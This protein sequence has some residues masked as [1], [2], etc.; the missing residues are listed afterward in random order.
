MC[1]ISG[2]FALDFET[3]CRHAEQILGAMAATLE[4]RGPDEVGYQ[5][6]PEVCFGFTR[7]AII[8]LETGQ[9]PHY[10][11][12]RSVVCI[13]NG[14]IYN[15]REL[16]EDLEKKGHRLRTRSDVEVL[17][18]LYEEHG[19][20]LVDR[21]NGQF[22]FALYDRSRRR[23]LGARDHVG[24]CP[25]YYCIIGGHLVFASEIKAI[26][27]YPGFQPVIDR[28]GLDQILTFPGLA[29]PRT[30]FEGV[31]ALP[32]GHLLIADGGA[33]RV[34]EYWDLEY[35][36]TGRLETPRNS[37]EVTEQLRALLTRAVERRLQADVPVGFYLSGGLDSTLVARLIHQLRPSDNWD[38]FS[39]GFDQAAIDEQR[40]QNIALQGIKAQRHLTLF[41]WKQISTRLPQAIWHAETPLKESYNTCSL[42]LSSMVR[43][44]GYKVILTGEGAD[45][46]FGGYVGYRLDRLRQPEEFPEPEHILEQDLREQLWGDRYFVY[47]RDYYALRSMKEAIYSEELVAGLDA[48][49]STCS[50]VVNLQRLVGR[51]PFHRRSYIDFKLR[52]ADHLLADHGD[53]VAMAN[54]VEARYPFLDI[55][56]I[57]FVRTIPPAMMIRDGVEKH[58]LKQAAAPLVPKE[59]VGREKF[60]FVAPG[61]DYLLRHDREFIMD[62]LSTERIKRDN[63]FNPATVAR[64]QEMARD[65][66]FTINQT[67]DNDLL[68]IILTF[69][70]FLDQF[71]QAH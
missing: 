44:A 19:D 59:I 35:P 36:Q 30:M 28:S 49:D 32:P 16:R 56:L 60:A 29:S 9:Q 12:D 8:D 65:E 18:H 6:G 58:L 24:I 55:E 57:E 21:L 47:E 31:K 53:R 4:H 67:F 1:G 70:I 25:F 61:S 41:D 38:C 34:C 51:D 43:G 37:D 2:Y 14:E 17:V 5:A 68:M 42:A 50:P 63:Y 54:S 52:I 64:L 22:A 45:E 69:N 26:F 10:N 23:F 46:L 13:C 3:D 33:P 27:Q 39:I 11:E 62:Y 71:S 7:L 66:G 20:A 15:H 40:F 48:F